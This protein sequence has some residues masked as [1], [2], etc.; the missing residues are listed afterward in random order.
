IKGRVQ[1]TLNR[2]LLGPQQPCLILT[3]HLLQSLLKSQKKKLNQKSRRLK[4]LTQKSLNIM[5]LRWVT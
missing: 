3:Q 5:K 4:A 2:P 1:S